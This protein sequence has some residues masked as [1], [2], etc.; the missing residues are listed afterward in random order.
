MQERVRPLAGWALIRV[1][2]RQEKTT[3]SGIVLPVTGKNRQRRAEV[4]AMGSPRF[5]ESGRL[6]ECEAKAGDA[7]FYMHHNVAQGI[8]NVDEEEGICLIPQEEIIGV[9][10]S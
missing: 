1:E 5:L 2:K 7:V 6:V 4:L 9:I 3:Q 8:G 10:E